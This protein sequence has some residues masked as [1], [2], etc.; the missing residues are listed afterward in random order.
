MAGPIMEPSGRLPSLIAM[1]I[2]SSLQPPIP[3]STSG[4][5]FDA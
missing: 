4:V 3:V 5:M 2:S 1:M